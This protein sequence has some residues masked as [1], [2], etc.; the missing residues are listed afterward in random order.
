MKVVADMPDFGR[1]A[2]N[3]NPYHNPLSISNQSIVQI[4]TEKL[5]LFTCKKNKLFMQQAPYQFF[6]TLRPK[7]KLCISQLPSTSS[8][9][10]GNST[11]DILFPSAFVPLS[12]CPFL[13]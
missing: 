10:I 5:K 13:W 3:C 7:A 9:D 2:G 4:I 6:P 12:L 11:F 8:L 1:K